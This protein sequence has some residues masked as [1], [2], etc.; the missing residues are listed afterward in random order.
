MKSKKKN[1]RDES[2][3]IG[4]LDFNDIQDYI[5]KIISWYNI[6]YPNSDLLLSNSKVDV[7]N[8]ENKTISD[9]MTDNELYNRLS[10]SVIESLKCNYSSSFECNYS[11]I[12]KERFNDK[13]YIYIQLMSQE[14]KFFMRDKEKDCFVVATKNGDIIDIIG[15]NMLLNEIL[16]NVDNL[17]IVQL[18][19][20]LKKSKKNI[21]DYY[22]LNKC[23]EHHKNDIIVRNNIIDTIS[24]MIISSAS[25][26]EYGYFR[27]LEFLND[28]S[29]YYNLKFDSKYFD[30][31]V[32]NINKSNFDAKSNKKIKLMLKKKNLSI[33]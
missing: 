1:K 18:L 26:V 22:H 16:K 31:I 5:F 20:I 6:K 28:F 19:G 23:V 33:K 10:S 24:K 25:N 3:T 11:D 15:N 29:N 2:V 17:N 14:K 7:M 8:K 13:D 12:K 27:A 21:L 9:Y 30:N 32:K 4:M